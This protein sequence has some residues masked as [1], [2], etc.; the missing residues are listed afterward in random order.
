MRRWAL[1]GLL[2]AAVG[3]AK[4]PK[5]ITISEA[6]KDKWTDEI[7]DLKGLTFDESRMLLALTMRQG[8]AKGLGQAPP[9]LV[10]KSVGDLIDEQRKFEASAKSEADA[11]ERLAAEAKAKEEAIAQELRKSLTFVP[12]E[13]GFYEPET[14]K[15]YITLKCAYQNT[16]PK[17]IRAFTGTLRFT[18]LFDKLIFESGLTVSDPIAAGAKANWSGSIEYNQFNDVQTRFKNADLKDMKTVWIPESI[19][20][21]DGSKAGKQ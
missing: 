13:K 21:A 9:S 15:S 12:I 8:L 1:V 2:A 16:G 14:Y 10:G 4:D 18:D 6:N 19:L 11:A 17:D 3:C 20:F 7:K 5:S